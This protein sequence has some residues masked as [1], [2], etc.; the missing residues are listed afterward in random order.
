MRAD[1]GSDGAV[2]GHDTSLMVLLRDAFVDV[3]RMKDRSGEEMF[4][5]RNDDGPKSRA[6]ASDTSRGLQRNMSFT[7]IPQA[8]TILTMR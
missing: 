6:I 1:G 3:V 7:G 8:H 5:S 4:T 2:R